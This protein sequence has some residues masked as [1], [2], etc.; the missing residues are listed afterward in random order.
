MQ[1]DDGVELSRT[2]DL[3]REAEPDLPADAAVSRVLHVS[4]ARADVR[5]IVICG[6]AI[7]ILGL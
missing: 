6:G 3:L 5:S 7:G 1:A 4:G 2:G